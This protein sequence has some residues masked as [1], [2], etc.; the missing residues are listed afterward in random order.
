MCINTPT[1]AITMDEDAELEMIR[2]RKMAMLQREME[3]VIQKSAYPSHPVTVTDL[4]YN[5]TIKKYPLVLVDFWA[6]WCGPCK[7]VGPV[8]DKL[9]QEM[10]GKA[11]FV[12]V[13]VDENPITAQNNKV[14][15]IP[16]LMIYKNGTLVD[17]IVGA[18]RKAALQERLNRH[19]PQE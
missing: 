12:K 17:R 15:S 9:A 2:K 8:V 6:P 4:D 14:M 10:Q 3:D 18:Q 11:V 13:N 5:D 7:M 16:T 1:E 19:L